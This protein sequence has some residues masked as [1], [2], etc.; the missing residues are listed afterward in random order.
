MGDH[1]IL[2][3]IVTDLTGNSTVLAVAMA[4]GERTISSVPPGVT[5]TV[6][7]ETL[8]TYPPT[9]SPTTPTYHG[10][11]LGADLSGPTFVQL[12][13]WGDWW[14]RAGNE[15]R[16]GLEQ[17]VQT[18]LASPYFDRLDQYRIFP[19]PTY[20]GS[21]VVTDPAPPVLPNTY[22]AEDI[23]KLVL[24]LIDADKFPEPDD[25]H[26]RLGFFVMMPDGTQWDQGDTGAHTKAIEKD[27]PFLDW[28]TSWVAWITAG[29]FDRM[30]RTFSHE[31]V[32][33]LTDPEMDGWYVD[34]LAEKGE[35]VDLCAVQ[36]GWVDGVLA[37]AYWSSS[38]AACVIPTRPLSV[39]IDGTIRVNGTKEAGSGNY[40]PQSTTGLKHFVPAC[41][42]ENNQYP[43]T[44]TQ[45]VEIGEIM[46]TAT[47]FHTP[48]YTW[49]VAG[50]QVAQGPSRVQPTLDLTIEHPEGPQAARQPVDL[51]INA[52]G[53]RLTITNDSAV[54][55]FD[56]PIAVTVTEA[57]RNYLT[58]AQNGSRT[59]AV[60][61]PFVGAEL[62]IGGT[63]AADLAR[64]KQAALEF[65]KATNPAT[66]V[67]VHGP[68]PGPRKD[69]D[70]RLTEIPGWVSANHFNELKA[71]LRQANV[72]ADTD[73]IA[74]REY[75]QLLFDRF[76]VSDPGDRP[77]TG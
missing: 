46:A 4:T 5:E 1:G 24:K 69:G 22:S 13:F 68:D 76:G 58:P 28:D 6:P 35:L 38:D 77:R 33:L 20:R 67:H 21:L 26:G 12:L 14:E 73:K 7:V 40:S 74:G 71:G 62:A 32:E 44:L 63:Y 18:L 52:E 25:E 64:C 3:R 29:D 10:G 75:R 42:L 55:N 27:F 50:I 23:R 61:A 41:H 48:S 2:Q 59:T 34:Q 51:A 57:P 53:A 39:R 70:R 11:L 31:L 17:A 60:V 30:T 19:H 9:Q 66:D 15:R 72:I 43:W 8:L 54:A 49:T 45:R 47:G 36:A 16:E 65:W 56:L 37:A